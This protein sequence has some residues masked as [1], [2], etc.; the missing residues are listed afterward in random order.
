[1][2]L[3]MMMMMMIV[4]CVCTAHVFW[5]CRACQTAQLDTSNVSCRVETWRAKWN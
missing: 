4:P 1:M 3:M 5:L 2:F